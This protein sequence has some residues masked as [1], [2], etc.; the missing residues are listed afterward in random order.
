V[1]F[2]PSIVIIIVELHVFCANIEMSVSPLLINL[3]FHIFDFNSSF[4]EMI[5]NEKG[6]SPEYFLAVV[7]FVISNVSVALSHRCNGEFDF[8]S[9]LKLFCVIKCFALSLIFSKDRGSHL[10]TTVGGVTTIGGILAAECILSVG[11]VTTVGGVL[12]TGGVTAEGVLLTGG[13][14]VGGVTIAGVVL[15]TGGVS[16]GGVTTAGGVTTTGGVTTA[17]AL[18]L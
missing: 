3:I 12:L 2:S 10:L 9:K 18:L 6:R 8:N 7:L 1:I 5:P 14:T 17:E 13:V 15:L 4:V 16:V 11:G